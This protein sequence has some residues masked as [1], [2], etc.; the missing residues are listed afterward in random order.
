MKELTLKTTYLATFREGLIFITRR[1]RKYGELLSAFV[2]VAHPTA[3]D[4]QT[5]EHVPAGSVWLQSDVYDANTVVRKFQSIQD[6]HETLEEWG[7]GKS[8]WSEA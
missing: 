8:P 6:A 1:R 2:V 5:G 7:K 3:T 4:R